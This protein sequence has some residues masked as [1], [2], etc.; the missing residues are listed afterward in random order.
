MKGEM[1]KTNFNVPTNKNRQERKNERGFG[2]L[3][4]GKMSDVEWCQKH[5]PLFKV[6]GKER[7]NKIHKK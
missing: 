3:A 7:W 4:M 1:V 6:K 5:D 2:K